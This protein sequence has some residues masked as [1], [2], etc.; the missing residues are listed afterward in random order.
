M[1]EKNVNVPSVV[2]VT[3]DTPLLPLNTV[4]VEGHATVFETTGLA[5]GALEPTINLDNKIIPRMTVQRL[6][7]DAATFQ[8]LSLQYDL[9]K[10]ASVG[11][12]HP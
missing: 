4:R 1:D 3:G 7:N 10:T 12:V 6:Q 11:S 9:R 2:S 8:K 5:L